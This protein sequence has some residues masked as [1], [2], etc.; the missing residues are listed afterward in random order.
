[1]RSLNSITSE[2]PRLVR[3]ANLA[4]DDST[5]NYKSKIIIKERRIGNTVN[6]S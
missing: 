3:F 4:I 6:N 2:G 5:D 1:M